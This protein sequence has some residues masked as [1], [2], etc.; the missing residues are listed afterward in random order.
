MSAINKGIKLACGDIVG[1]LHSD[2]LF[3][4]DNVI[5]DIISNFFPFN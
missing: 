2:D 4:D 1:I 3:A 5:D